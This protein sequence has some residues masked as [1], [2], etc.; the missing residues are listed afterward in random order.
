MQKIIGERYVPLHCGKWDTT[1]NTE[2]GSLSVV[3]YGGKSYTSKKPVPQGVD[4]LNTEYWVES[5]DYNE[6]Y[7]ILSDKVDSFNL[8]NDNEVTSIKNKVSNIEQEQQTQ[9]TAIAENDASIENLRIGVNK[10]TES[11]EALK[12]KATNN[13]N[14]IDTIQNNITS[15]T[16]KQTEIENSNNDI[17]SYIDELK[18]KL[19]NCS[20]LKVVNVMDFGAKGDGLTDDTLAIQKA[21]DSIKPKSTATISHPRGGIVFFPSGTYIVTN[22]II[23]PAQVILKGEGMINTII[24]LGKGVSKDV[25]KT[26]NFDTLI[27]TNASWYD[28]YDVPMGF[29]I[30]NICIDGNK[31]ENT[32]GNG[33]QVYGYCYLIENVS[34]IYC[35]ESGFKSYHGNMINGT[36]QYNE[37]WTK[38]F[39]TKID[40]LHIK[41]CNKRGFDYK[42]PTDST[43]DNIFIAECYGDY[44]SVIECSCNMGLIHI[45][46]CNRNTPSGAGILING[47]CSIENLISENNY[48]IGVR[49]TTYLAHIYRCDLYANRNNNLLIAENSDYTKIDSLLIRPFGHDVHNV[50]IDSANI[51]LGNLTIYGDN[52]SYT[53][54]GIFISDKA[55]NLIIDNGSIANF[56]N[57]SYGAMFNQ[58]GK[59]NGTRINLNIINCANAIN[60]GAGFGSNNSI[61]IKTSLSATQNTL[62]TDTQFIDENDNDIEINELKGN[63]YKSYV[64][65]STLKFNQNAMTLADRNEHDIPINTNGC[66]FISSDDNIA[67]INSNGKLIGVSNG[68]CLLIASKNDKIAILKIVVNIAS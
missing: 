21:I 10:N 14:S 40:N 65:H 45:Y 60:L 23:L 32:M 50:T 47:N 68:S 64:N 12:T 35:A 61:S 18:E 20:N 30:S 6:Q 8:S 42:A 31:T 15:I 36:E 4:I 66:Q 22:T 5:F 1:K 19:N 59:L 63:V 38:L 52:R 48:G 2:Y 46:G 7:K 16:N 39:E 49:I 67:N 33:I 13:K 24:R 51:H 11:I 53:K 55:K 56:D 44:G 54:A 34:V 43:L 41:Y 62:P 25:I 29:G 58:G 28:T 26:E 3:Y 27:N 57:T 17:K 37:G 9:N